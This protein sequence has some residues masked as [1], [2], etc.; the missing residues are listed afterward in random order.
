MAVEVNQWHEVSAGRS[1]GGL[2]YL[3]VD[4]E[5]VINEP[6]VGRATAI[7][8]KSNVFVGGY[9]KRIL[10]NRGVGVTRGFEGCVADVSSAKQLNC[11]TNCFIMGCFFNFSLKYP[12]M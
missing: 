10:L 8:L 5:P 7:A 3:Q 6:R 2:A 9:D 1:R 4:E 12:E 11:P